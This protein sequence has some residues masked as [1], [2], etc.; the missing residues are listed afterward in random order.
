MN[1]IRVDGIYTSRVEPRGRA[2]RDGIEF[3]TE[4]I[5]D[6]FKEGPSIGNED[7]DVSKEFS[8][9]ATLQA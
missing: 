4:A 8:Q 6:L 3:I 7:R 5:A 2:G 9:I 1:G